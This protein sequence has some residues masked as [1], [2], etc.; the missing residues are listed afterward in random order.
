MIGKTNRAPLTI[1]ESWD[2]A[3]ERTNFQAAV[4]QQ[5]AATASAAGGEGAVMDA[6]IAPVNPSICPKHGD[7]SRVRYLA[8][9]STVNLLDL[10]A[11]TVPWTFV[12]KQRP[13]H[14]ADDPSGERDAAGNPIPAPTCDL[15]RRIRANY[16]PVVYDGLPVTVQV[17]AR[18]LEEEKVIAIAKVLERLRGGQG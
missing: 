7:Y 4:L 12:D 15:D 6:Y 8:Y 10:S 11:C 2:L 18:K 5:W 1:L 17:V 13:A 3:V 9:V 16:D 14:Q